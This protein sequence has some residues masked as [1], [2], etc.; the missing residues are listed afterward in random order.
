[1]RTITLLLFMCIAWPSTAQALE[2]PNTAQTVSSHEL[3]MAHSAWM[4]NRPA[5]ALPILYKQA[6]ASDAWYDYFDLGRAAYDNGDQA[7]AIAWLLEAH[8]RAPTESAP[9][10]ALLALHVVLPASW[11]ARLGPLSTLGTGTFGVLFMLSAGLCLG[12]ACFS[13]K[14][15]WLLIIIAASSLVLAL[16]GSIAQTL[17][18]QQKLHAI[19]QACP[20]LDPTGQP[21]QTLAPGTIVFEEKI[22]NHDRMLIR[23]QNDQRGFIDSS[24]C[25]A[26]I[27]P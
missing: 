15:R 26:Q 13:Q 2:A 21:L 16:P 25:H 7:R 20:L 1:M 17:D 8:K 10:E 3:E 5:E 11:L 6:L 23:L 9:R 18:Q 27:R 24:N 4:Q 12:L 14:R 22:H 19:V